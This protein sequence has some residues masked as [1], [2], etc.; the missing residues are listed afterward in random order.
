MDARAVAA[1]IV[2][3]T[4]ACSPAPAPPA[5]R[6][7]DRPVVRVALFN[8]RELSVEKIEV[9]DD[10]GAGEHPQLR[11]VAA[12]VARYDPDI[13]V[14][15]EIDAPDATGPAGPAQRFTALYLESG[16][17][18]FV[19]SAP[20]NTGTLSGLDLNGDGIVATDEHRDDRIHG[21]DAFG[22]GT[23]QGQYGMSVLSRHPIR[24]DDARSFQRFLWK[25][26]P[27]NHMPRDFYSDEATAVLRLS[28]KSHWDVPLDVNG[29]MLHLLISHPTPPVFDGD[30][31]RNGRR[32]FD[33]I[34]LWAH[35]LDDADWLGDDSGRSGGL[36]NDDPFVVVGDLNASP[37]NDVIY[38]G[39]A[40]ISQLLDHPRV[41]ESGP[42]LTSDRDL[43]ERRPGP[44]THLERATAKFQG[45]HRID[46][47]LPSVGT[48]IVDGGVHWPNA[49]TDRA[50]A[51]EAETASDH[52][53]IW[54]DLRLGETD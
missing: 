54:L 32:N 39:R 28:S 20:T 27:G 5:E 12:I 8:V 11:A 41:Q 36:G 26:F 42:N 50:G 33:E 14:L 4:A 53:F 48:E 22:F 10:T 9:V 24:G 23:Y 31:D 47:L 37:D 29:R 7:G 3:L 25:D 16:A 45:G 6:A 51:E 34:G 30:E 43:E 2:A 21:D 13:L 1:A 35:Y 52:R 17:Y 18:P 46:Y 15:Q 19:F 38:A 49:A 44:P 40:S